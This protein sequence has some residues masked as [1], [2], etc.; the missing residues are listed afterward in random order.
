MN[1]VI[2]GDYKGYGINTNF[3]KVSIVHGFKTNVKINSETVDSFKEVD[4][5]EKRSAGKTIAGGALLG[6][7]GA[8][9]GATSKKHIHTC[10]VVFK[11]GKKSLI[12]L[13]DNAFK[14]LQ[15]EMF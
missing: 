8:L 9:L 6:G 4:K 5:V 12:E 3:S 7:V 1:R 13:D 11:D 10:K 2:A 15:K 14:I